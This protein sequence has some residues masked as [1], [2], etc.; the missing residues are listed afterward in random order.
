[1]IRLDRRQVAAGLAALGAMGGGCARGDA[2]P[3]DPAAAKA[4]S[5][6]YDCEGCEVVAERNP[7]DLSPSL[8]LA[9]PDE[10]GE[11]LQ[12]TGRVVGADG[13]TPVQ[14]VVI[15]AHQTNA[16]GLY[17]NGTPESVWS[18]RHGRLRGWVRSDANGLY[19]F[20]TIKPAPYP[21][22]T[23]PAHIHLY[24]QEP[25]R[26]AYYIDDVVF[27]GEFGVDAAYRAAQEL[28]GGS[29]IVRLVRGAGSLTADRPIRLERHPQ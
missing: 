28:R 14:G 18:R 6:L 13:A 2:A 19:A 3:A 26:R 5:N 9:A 27:D 17:A 15:Y 1:M 21:D 25:G 20:D 29:G 23:M 12:L 10:P 7:A 22:M 8:V 16:Q 11:R 24:I 4:R